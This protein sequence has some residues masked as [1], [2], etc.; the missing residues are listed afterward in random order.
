MLQGLLTAAGG[1]LAIEARQAV[2]ANNIANA[3]TPG[4]KRQTPVTLGFDAVFSEKAIHPFHFNRDS[5]PGGGARIVETYPDLGPG[6]LKQ[7]ANPLNVALDGPGYIA[8]ET[9]RGERFTRSG[10]FTVDVDGQLAT[11]DGFK[12]QSAAGLPI[13]ALGKNVD[14][15]STGMVIID[16]LPAGRIRIVEFAQPERL[17]REGK[18]LFNAN[19]EVLGQSTDAVDTMLMQSNLEMSN[20]N[21][22]REMTSMILGVRAYETNQRVIQ[23]FDSTIGHLIERVGMP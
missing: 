9:P 11:R 4:Y 12:V 1:M 7:T 13:D 15:A 14:I 3:A 18:N 20:V 5:A 8:V 21:M 19:D 6:A 17:L 2:I 23:A 22:P 10:D 16:G